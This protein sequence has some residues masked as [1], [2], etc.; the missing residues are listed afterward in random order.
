MTDRRRLVL[1]CFVIR[2]NNSNI[3]SNNNSNNNNNKIIFLF[4]VQTDRLQND[5]L[6]GFP[7]S[8]I[9]DIFMQVCYP[10]LTLLF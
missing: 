7:G 9:F 6:K 8:N 3:I 10:L 4:N 1:P 5:L 2:D